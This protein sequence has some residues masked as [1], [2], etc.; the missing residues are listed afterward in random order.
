MLT[1]R[2]TNRYFVRRVQADRA[3]TSIVEAGCCA[4]GANKV[5]VRDNYRL[6]KA[7]ASRDASKCASDASGAH[8]Q[9]S[10]EILLSYA[11]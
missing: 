2:G 7:T 8:E 3:E 4:L 9:D 11:E 6:E 5:V 1:E 10:H